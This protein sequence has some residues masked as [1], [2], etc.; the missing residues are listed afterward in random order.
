LRIIVE[1]KFGGKNSDKVD[2]AL[3]SIIELFSATQN[4]IFRENKM[5]D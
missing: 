1:D 4:N 3:R 5:I 2:K